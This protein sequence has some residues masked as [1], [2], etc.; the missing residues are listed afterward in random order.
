MVDYMLMMNV[1]ETRTDC[2]GMIKERYADFRNASYGMEVLD[3]IVQFYDQRGMIS[4]NLKE[5]IGQLICRWKQD[6][7]DLGYNN[8]KAFMGSMEAE[9]ML[10]AEMECEVVWTRNN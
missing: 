4:E 5:R 3:E 6:F 8:L 9:I 1:A 7:T 10:D 2:L